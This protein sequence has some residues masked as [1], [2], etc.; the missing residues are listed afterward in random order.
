MSG[1]GWVCPGNEGMRAGPFVTTG[2]TSGSAGAG[3]TAC[4]VA[5]GA[6]RVPALIVVNA[7]PRNARRLIMSD[8]PQRQ[9]RESFPSDLDL[10]GWP[11]GGPAL[12]ERAFLIRAEFVG[13]TIG[14]K[15]ET[16]HAELAIFAALELREAPQPVTH[17][18]DHGSE[19]PAR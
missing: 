6:R 2:H 11:H 12:I 3:M 15:G 10:T 14:G 18:C 9:S 5:D 1:R 7:P 17:V 16:E 8:L 19:P 13:L 4:A